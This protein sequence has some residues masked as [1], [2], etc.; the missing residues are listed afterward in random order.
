[1]HLRTRRKPGKK[2]LLRAH[3][4]CEHPPNLT[5]YPALVLL[6]ID[7]AARLAIKEALAEGTRV[8]QRCGLQ[9]WLAIADKRSIVTPH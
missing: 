5:L 3:R 6:R 9:S 8:E 7:K 2:R 4:A 1:M